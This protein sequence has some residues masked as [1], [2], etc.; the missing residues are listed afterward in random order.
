VILPRAWVVHEAR[1]SASSRSEILYPGDVFWN[2]PGMPVFDLRMTAWVEAGDRE[3]LGA[4]LP[5]GRLA[6]G[7]TVDVRYRGPQRDELDAQLERPGLV[8]LADVFYPGWRLTIDG[9]PAPI[10]RVNQ[11]MRGAAVDA[12]RHRLVFA[13][14]PWSFRIGTAVTAMGVLAAGLLWLRASGRD[15]MAGDRLSTPEEHPP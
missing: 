2:E 6:P 15:R 7:E 14:E 8:V 5:G 10:F 12:G 1:H 9:R 13:Y 3:R 11:G 4:H